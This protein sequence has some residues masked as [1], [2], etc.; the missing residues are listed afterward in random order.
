MNNEGK[1]VLLNKHL[2]PQ[3]YLSNFLLCFRS[4]LVLCMYSLPRRN[5]LTTVCEGNFIILIHAILSQYT[6]SYIYIYIY[7]HANGVIEKITNIMNWTINSI[8]DLKF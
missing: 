1:L 5:F 3:N 7:I 8:H 2:V 4:T 6:S